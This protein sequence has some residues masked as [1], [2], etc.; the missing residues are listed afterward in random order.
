MNSADKF[1]PQDFSMEISKITADPK[2][3]AHIQEAINSIL[4]DRNLPIE[5]T[6]PDNL[7]EGGEMLTVGL[8]GFS[9]LE[10]DQVE[11]SR[12]FIETVFR[13]LLKRY[14]NNQINLISGL[15]DYGIPSLGYS[16]A[17]ALNIVNRNI[18]WKLIGIAPAVAEAK[19]DPCQIF[20]VDEKHIKGE[21]WGE[22]SEF[23]V[24]SVKH[25]LI[26]VG[27][28]YQANHE[29]DELRKRGVIIIE[30]KLQIKKELLDN[31]RKKKNSI[32]TK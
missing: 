18:Q 25:I 31:W 15:T 1:R 28:G 30:Y 11:E 5:V 27:G 21:K 32:F 24:N 16:T 10:A 2:I 17:K 8:V 26:K 13:A 6:I 3:Q 9:D 4:K 7:V 12:M 22:D 14:P 20:P 23:F 19:D 29:A